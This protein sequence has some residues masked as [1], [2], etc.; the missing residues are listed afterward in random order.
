MPRPD[1]AALGVSYRRIPLLSLGR[2]IYCD[3]RLMLQKL[4]AHFPDGALGAQG[5]EGK[6]L[7]RLLEKWTFDAGMFA[8]ASQLLPLNLP[9]LKNSVFTKDREQYSGRS[10]NKESMERARPEALV[11]LR[12][13]FEFLETTLLAD[14][15]EWILKTE[16][17]SL[18]DIEGT[19][20]FA[21]TRR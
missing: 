11:H 5:S 14:G 18:A 20:P 4:E 1:L 10:W 16:K 9:L 7:E 13:G 3:S 8:R 2:D 15:R 19:N 21:E 17:P 6:A 12:E